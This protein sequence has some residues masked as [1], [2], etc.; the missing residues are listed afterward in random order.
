MKVTHIYNLLPDEIPRKRLTHAK[1]GGMGSCANLIASLEVVGLTLGTCVRAWKW[2]NPVRPSMMLGYLAGFL[3]GMVAA[4][5]DE[6]VSEAT[7]IAD[8]AGFLLG[9]A[10]RCGVNDKRLQRSEARL[11]ELIA[12]FSSDDEDQKTG[13]SQFVARA[14]ASALAQFRGDP[15]PSCMKCELS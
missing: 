13:Q 11:R 15:T 10:H 1:S 12:A 3:L 9:H 8:R 7:V 4:Q 14:I 6:G 5:A 2:I